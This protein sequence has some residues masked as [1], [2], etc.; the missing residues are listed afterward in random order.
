[1]HRR[2]NDDRKGIELLRVEHPIDVVVTLEQAATRD[3]LDGRTV[4]VGDCDELHVGDLRPDSRVV[5]AHRS[6]PRDSNAHGHDVPL[7]RR[8]IPR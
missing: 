7:V 3:P 1:M 2:R 6:E 8:P 4:H 5:T